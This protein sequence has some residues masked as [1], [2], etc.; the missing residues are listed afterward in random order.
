MVKVCRLRLL[1]GA[2]LLAWWAIH[3]HRQWQAYSDHIVAALGYQGKG[4]ANIA[5]TG[6]GVGKREMLLSV[7]TQTAQAKEL[8]TGESALVDRCIRTASGSIQ[9]FAPRFLM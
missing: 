2:L 5:G 3:Y 4:V 6:T 1:F 9:N 8:N 7:N